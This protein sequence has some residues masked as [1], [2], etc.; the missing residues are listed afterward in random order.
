MI[1]QSAGKNFGYILGVYLGDGNLARTQPVFRLNTIDKDFAES[2]VKALDALTGSKGKVSCNSVRKNGKRY[3][4]NYCLWYPIPELYPVLFKDTKDKQRIPPYVFK[5]PIDVKRAFISGLMDSEGFVAMK[6]RDKTTKTTTGRSFYIGYKSCDT[7]VPDLIKIFHSV[8]VKTGK[9]GIEKPR[10]AGYKTPMR[11]A[12]NMQS[13]VD[14][15]CRFNIGRKQDRVD[16]WRL[17]SP[18]SQRSKAPKLTSETNMLSA[19]IHQ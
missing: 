13:W 18:Y 17:T 9:V 7:W 16:I 4:D 1:R 15:G 3:R 8:G 19:D 12:I 11:F 2:A 6:G 5:W 10:K 14:S